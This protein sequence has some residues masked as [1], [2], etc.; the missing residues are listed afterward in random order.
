M[1][2][3]GRC[4]KCGES[5]KHTKIENVP[6]H[7]G[8]RVRGHGVVYLCPYCDTVLGAGLDPGV[9]VSEIIKEIKKNNSVHLRL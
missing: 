5:V 4:P 7:E 3:K 6:V 1:H 2:K 9:L 8:A